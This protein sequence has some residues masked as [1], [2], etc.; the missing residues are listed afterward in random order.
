LTEREFSDRLLELKKEDTMTLTTA[1]L[2]WLLTGVVCFLLEMA[3]PGFVIFFFGVGA[4]VTSIMCW[5]MPISLNTQLATFLVASL[6][7]LLTLRPLI[8]KTFLVGAADG[9][10]DVI[11]T[12][13]DK[14]VV[15][16]DI[17]PPAEGKVSYS[18]SLW[19]ALADQKI[20]K[21][22]T[23]TI[24]SQDGVCMKVTRSSE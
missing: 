7:S 12:A 17:V 13:G 15:V 21:G 11:I 5:L 23:V 24:V 20:E 18:G 10:D 14:A 1:G 16:E 6:V 2:I 3:L 19:R 22:N 8:R 9:G 4:W